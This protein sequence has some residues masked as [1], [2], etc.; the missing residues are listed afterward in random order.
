[1]SVTAKNLIASKHAAGSAT[2]EYT[3]AAATRVI[4]DKFTATNIT[5]GAITLTIYLV[6]SGG[7]AGASNTIISALSIAA[8]ATT[9][10]TQLQNQILNSGDFVSVF[11]SAAT[12]IVIRMSGR[13]VV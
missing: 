6:P 4:I 2:T 10:L 9:D 11:A 3:A 13:E 1:M 12:S 5:G 8:G 7:S